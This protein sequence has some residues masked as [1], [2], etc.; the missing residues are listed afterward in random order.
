MTNST[1]SVVERNKYEAF[2]KTTFLAP[3][4]LTVRA[5]SQYGNTT[6]FTGRTLDS[7]GLMYYRAR[8]MNPDLGRF[9]EI[10]PIASFDVPLGVSPLWFN[11]ATLNSTGVGGLV[12]KASI[13]Y[14][15]DVNLYDYVEGRPTTRLDP[16]G[17]WAC[18]ANEFVQCQKLCKRLYPGAFGLFG[19]CDEIWWTCGL[20]VSCLC[21]CR[22]LLNVQINRPGGKVWCFYRCPGLKGRPE[23]KQGAGP[24]AGAIQVD[25]MDF[26]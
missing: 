19:E 10:D 3:D 16:T 7:S 18:T 25:C 20:R 26:K 4:G 2:G 8:Q 1:G 23:T 9:L 17:E 12:S 24:C 13:G 6:T 15:G 11:L 21:K 5:Q 14:K 22:C